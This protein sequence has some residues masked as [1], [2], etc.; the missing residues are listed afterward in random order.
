VAAVA[1][2]IFV[3]A[4]VGWCLAL[5]TRQARN[6]AVVLT[7]ALLVTA[8]H[9]MVRQD[10]HLRLFT[11]FGIF[12]VVLLAVEAA[13]RWPPS[14]IVVAVEI[15]LVPLLVVWFRPE[16]APDRALG[17][18]DLLGVLESPGQPVLVHELSILTHPAARERLL[19]EASAPVL[20]S[21]RLSPALRARIGDATVDVYPTE[22]SY[23][24]ANG[25]R[26][27]NRPM[28][29]S[30]LAYTPALDGLDAAFL[31]SPRRP[32]LVLWHPS[33]GPPMTS[34]D[35]RHLFWDEPL[36]L[37]ALLDGYRLVAEDGDLLLLGRRADHR[38]GPP[39]PLERRAVDWGAWTAVPAAPGVVL[40][41]VHFHRGLVPAL[42]RSVFREEASFLSVRL[43]SGE[44]RTFR[45]V[46][47][48]MPSG[49]WISPLPLATADLRALLSGSDDGPRVMAIRLHGGTFGRLADRVEV[50][51]LQLAPAAAAAALT[52]SH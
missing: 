8:R 44:E 12:V 37:R 35:N 9:A 11:A 33:E 26:W 7:V 48:Q 46:P 17:F 18:Q 31:A 4:V 51:W 41:E 27:A 6:A 13:S 3:L 16:S 30:Y 47:D 15:L 36:A 1:I 22:H 49:I 45:V 5:K 28:L 2:A 32:Q 10:S 34:I 40:A 24:P 19:A 50:R 52:A 39:R 23:V 14:R 25:L 42:V 38:W 29:S 20:A 21:R 43:A